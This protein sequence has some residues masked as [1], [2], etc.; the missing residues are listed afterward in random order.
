MGTVGG[1]SS[2]PGPNRHNVE[3]P[4]MRLIVIITSIQYSLK[5]H[6]QLGSSATPRFSPY[7]SQNAAQRT[8]GLRIASYNDSKTSLLRLLKA[9]LIRLLFISQL[10]QLRPSRARA[11]PV[12]P[13]VASLPDG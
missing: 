4:R 1:C 11:P 6:V 12:R 10:P 8:K 3:N 9:E 5:L 13:I 2:P 7:N